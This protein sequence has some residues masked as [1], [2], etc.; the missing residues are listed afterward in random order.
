M[1]HSLFHSWS[2][3]FTRDRHIHQSSV[4]TIA[5]RTNTL[6]QVKEEKC[7]VMFPNS[8]LHVCHSPNICCLCPSVFT[9][10][11]LPGNLHP[12]FPS[13]SPT[14]S[15]ISFSVFASSEEVFRQC[16]S[17]VGSSHE[18]SDCANDVKHAES[19]QEQTVDDGRGKLPLLC[20]TELPVLL[21]DTFN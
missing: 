5:K 4:E 9:A 20:Q 14:F 7:T 13:S 21:P 11:V 10:V 1:I 17:K 2:A 15:N 18:N 3:A 12:Y 8:P 19:H 16:L 6:S